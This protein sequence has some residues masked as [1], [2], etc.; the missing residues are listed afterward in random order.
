MNTFFKERHKCEKCYK[1]FHFIQDLQTHQKSNCDAFGKIPL[2]LDEMSMIKTTQFKKAKDISCWD[3]E[4]DQSSFQLRN[5]S[6]DSKV[7]SL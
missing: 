5:T 7:N 3:E 4:M 6:I 1:K 2:I